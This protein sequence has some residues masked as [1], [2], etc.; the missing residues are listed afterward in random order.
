MLQHHWFPRQKIIWAPS[1]FLAP[2]HIHTC[3]ANE[4]IWDINIPTRK[5][6]ERVRC[7]C[8]SIPYN[9]FTTL[10]TIYMVQD[11]INFLNMLPSKN[12][13]PSDLSLS[14]IIQGSWNPDCN[15]L[16]ITLGAYAQLYKGTNNSTKQIMVGA[17][18][19]RPENERGGY[20]FISL[21]TGKQLHF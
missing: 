9:K 17:I 6:K 20:Y 8:H 15:K 18:A 10:M 19:L 1:R 11:R 5:I 16:R 7:G 14:A 3:A 21:S 4:H 13:I 2:D 12:G